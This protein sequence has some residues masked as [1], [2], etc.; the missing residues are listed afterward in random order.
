MGIGVFKTDAPFIDIGT[1]EAIRE[2]ESFIKKHRV[3]FIQEE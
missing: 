3:K 1:P 2:A